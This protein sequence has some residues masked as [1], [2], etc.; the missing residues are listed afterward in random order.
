MSNANE[1]AEHTEVEFP[2]DT[3]L[4]NIAFWSRTIGWL[5]IIIGVIRTGFNFLQFYSFG[6]LVLSGMRPIELTMFIF[7]NIQSLFSSLL[8]WIILL[9]VKELLFL[10]IDIKEFLIL[11]PSN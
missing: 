1:V 4:F 11:N 5:I 3:R 2:E 7:N 6:G 9:V 10:M 8:L